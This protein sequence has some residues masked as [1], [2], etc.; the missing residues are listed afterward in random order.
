[1][2]RK[3]VLGGLVFGTGWAITGACPGTVTAMSGT[4]SLLGFV[5]LAGVI[6]GIALHDTMVDTLPAPGREPTKDATTAGS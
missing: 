1:V 3:H 6:A 2:E 4:G 5:L